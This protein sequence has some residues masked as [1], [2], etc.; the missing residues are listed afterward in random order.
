[1]NWDVV[2][3]IAEILGAIGVIATLFYLSYQI[4][5]NTR[6]NLATTTESI[7]RDIHDFSMAIFKDEDANKY[8][9]DY[10]NNGTPL[11]EIPADDR[12]KMHLLFQSAFII[13]WRSFEQF[14]NDQASQQS[15]EIIFGIVKRS[16]CTSQTVKDWFVTGREIFPEDFVTLIDAEWKI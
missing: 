6:S 11:A 8:F 7:A 3:A 4:R 14:K 1:M 9:R 5:E 13:T 16:Y 15:W 12:F 10:V 2:S